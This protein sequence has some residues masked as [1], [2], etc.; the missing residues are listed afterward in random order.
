MGD[1]DQSFNQG[2]QGGMQLAQQGVDTQIKRNQLD[3]LQSYQADVQSVL[4]DPNANPQAYAQIALKYPQY[5]QQVQTA[6]SV[7]QVAKQN[8]DLTTG[9]QVY[10]SLEAGDNQ[11]AI[12]V[13]QNK[14]AAQQNSGAST[15]DIQG[16]QH[17]I[18]LIGISPGYAKRLGGLFLAQQLGPEKFT[19]AFGAINNAQNA[20]QL[21]PAAVQKTQAEADT[22]TAN[23]ANQPVANDLANQKTTADIKNVFDT[24]QNRAATF[25]L[26][27]DQ[28]KATTAQKMSE[29]QYNQRVPK[30]ADGMAGV[31]AQAVSDAVQ[32]QQ[33]ASQ[34]TELAQQMRAQN[35]GSSGV[36]NSTARSFRE[37]T[38]QNPTQADVLRK[39]YAQIRSS[40]ILGGNNGNRATDTDVKLL[41]G[42]Y[43]ADNAPLPQV[44]NFLDAVSRVR[45]REAQSA[46]AK[47]EWISQS[48]TVGAAPQDIR[49]AGVLVPK[50]MTF[51]GFLAKNPNL[52]EALAQPNIKTA[53]G[54]PGAGAG[55]LTPQ[56][57]AAA[58]AAPAQPSYMKYAQ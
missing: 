22:A 39:Q 47:A 18:D 31:Q 29:L 25:G 38:G 55:V 32:S 24:M 37:W 46:N 43:P 16:T 49:V 56:G 8:V 42:G 28:F 5:A 15:A 7:Q 11:G 14:L 10:A 9:A 41:S 40:G 12:G 30:L 44:A 52:G 45:A 6:Q 50:G 34:A 4:H 26:D 54:E 23:A 35:D 33:M 3:Q 20:N 51:S 58:T 36:I 2:L 19:A 21:Q 57:G 27:T 13:L 48:G 1:F 17:M 53:P